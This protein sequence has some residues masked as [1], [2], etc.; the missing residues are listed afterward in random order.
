MQ[1]E[2]DEYDALVHRI[3]DAALAPE[4]L[5]GVLES[6][7]VFARSPYSNIFSWT[8]MPDEGG[9]FFS[10]FPPDTMSRYAVI[11][12]QDPHMN[13]AMARGLMEPSAIVTNDELATRDQ[14][15]NSRL[16]QEIW[17]PLRIV[18]MCG[19][20]VFGASDSHYLPTVLSLHRLDDMP[21]FGPA[22]K[23]LMARIL[24]H[25]SRSIG[26]MFHLRDQSLQI[27][28]SQAALNRLACGV[29]ILRAGALVE[30]ANRSAESLFAANHSIMVRNGRLV[31][32]ASLRA[33]QG[34]LD[35]M[36]RKAL[37]PLAADVGDNFASALIL[38]GDGGSPA[39]VIHAAPLPANN[40]LVG[41]A[42]SQRAIVFI[43]DMQAALS[44]PSNVLSEA[45][46]LTKG[47]ARV[48]MESLNGG[49]A[50]AVAARLRLSPN[51]VKTHMKNI[52][53]KMAITQ[54]A[55]F[56]KIMLSLAS[57]H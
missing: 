29:V 55:D 10:T 40:S 56:L 48:A 8:R 27:A 3:Y 39:A 13:S 16:Y 44:V 28:S 45:F 9:F 19:G 23:E 53:Q 49:T 33:Q 41:S 47:E 24:A 12:D 35:R 32:A 37:M 31:V 17:K 15:L 18:Q 7:C 30:F 50:D 46:G 4:R 54:R 25:L 52:Y 43:Y 36:L 42:A 6:I 22:D 57:R 38:Q 34:A 5:Q 26:V 51:T 11:K 20:S 14:L 1:P 2:L 21:G